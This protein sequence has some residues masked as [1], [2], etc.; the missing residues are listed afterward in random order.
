MSFK[1]MFYAVE[2]HA[3]EPMRVV[4]GG[5]PHIPGNTVYEQM[6]WLKK[7]DDQIRKLM[8][9]EPRGYPP[10]CCNLIVPPKHPDAA[11][12]YIIMEQV[13]YPV[14]SGGN[15][16]SVAT[17]L[18]ET[19]MLPMQ[20]PVTEFMLEAPAGLIGIRAECHNGKVTN[21]TFKNVPA[22]AAHLDAVIDVPELGKVTVDVAWGGMFYVIADV[23]QF[24]WIKLVPEQGAEIA[25]V[26]SLILRAAQDQLPVEH[27]DY[28]GVGITISQLSGPADNP[29]SDWKN[30]VTVA[31]GDVDFANPATWTGAIDRCPCGT[32]TCAK[33]AVLHAKGKLGLNQAFR[34]EGILGNIFT[35]HLVEEVQIG[36]YKGVVPT[37]GGQAWIYGYSTYVL[38][39]TDPFTEGFT[40]GDIWA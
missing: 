39:P 21:V 15:T 16:I 35:G 11:M 22:F 13:E 9:R 29:D 36:K 30:A 20:E 12:G 24:D 34:H 14:M 5:V 6:Q 4:T 8:L 1:R 28:P 19:G 40:V 32:G 10:L 2:T 17:V 31:S 26:S 37:V 3:G 7:N 25:R 23:R 18:L 33:M 38:D 27:P